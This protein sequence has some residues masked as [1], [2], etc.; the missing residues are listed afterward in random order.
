MSSINL[1]FELIY[2][3]E[4]HARLVFD[5][6]SQWPTLTIRKKKPDARRLAAIKRSMDWLGYEFNGVYQHAFEKQNAILEKP[7]TKENNTVELVFY[8]S[9]LSGNQFFRIFF[10]ELSALPVTITGHFYNDMDGY[11]ESKSVKINKT[12]LRKTIS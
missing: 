4:E 12:V 9:K 1:H 7:P 10:E 6:F 8:C 11:T 5:A 2:H 3:D